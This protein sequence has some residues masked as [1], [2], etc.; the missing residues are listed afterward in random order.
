MQQYFALCKEGPIERAE[1][2]VQNS[3]DYMSLIYMWKTNIIW[4]KR[5]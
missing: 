3:I 4:H 5:V 2:D 1:N